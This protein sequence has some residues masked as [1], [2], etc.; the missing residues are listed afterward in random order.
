MLNVNYNT[1]I[2]APF[3]K[4]YY[5][6]VYQLLA[7]NLNVED[8]NQTNDTTQIILD[9]FDTL[10]ITPSISHNAPGFGYYIYEP[11]FDISL[12][13]PSNSILQAIYL[14]IIA[15]LPLLEAKLNSLINSLNI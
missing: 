15:I 13:S 6:S 3:V 8:V 9:L 12:F 2:P 4:S 11:T 10:D 5:P 7:S 14:T 1:N